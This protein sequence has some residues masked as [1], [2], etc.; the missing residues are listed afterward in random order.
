MMNNIPEKQSQE[1][2]R[3]LLIGA[4]TADQSSGT[5]AEQ[6][7]ELRLLVATLNYD[8]E[9]LT[10]PLKRIDPATF[11]GS[12]KVAEIKNLLEELKIDEIVFNDDL[13][14][15]QMRNLERALEMEI[16]DRSGIILEI[17]AS[18]A[19]T[20]EAKTQVELATLEYLLP[21][22][23]R[24]WTHLERQIGGIN[25]RGGAGE[26]QIETDKRLIKVRISRLKK[27]L[28]RIEN[29]RVVQRK[30]RRGNYN[31]SLVGYTNAGKSTLMNLFTGS[32][33]LVEDKLF[34]TLDTTV[35][36]CQLD[37]F[38]RILLSDT[39]GFIR[40]LPHHL[41]AS[42]RGTLKEIEEADLIV[43]VAD[44]SHPQ[45]L[46][47]LQTVEEVM[48]DLKVSHKPSIVVFNKID[49]MDKEIFSDAKRIYPDAVFLSALNRLKT[50]DLRR[51]VIA[52]LKKMEIQMMIQIPLS[53]VR[54]IAY[55]RDHA[56]IL[57]EKYSDEHILLEII[58]NR[59]IW[60][61][62]HRKF[63]KAAIQPVLREE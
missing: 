16:R 23:T 59:K 8:G 14:P 50:D 63:G 19:R 6:L 4:V 54:D 26:T 40:K 48:A 30:S 36:Q 2:E 1:M 55:V 34:A 57:S 44:I 62:I 21:R 7:E 46:V 10:V 12:G 33:V 17:F 47:H 22:L 28:Q 49:R 60:E 25:V 38:H 11:I 18:H 3:V 9:I 42:F 43:K 31:V 24:R 56:F 58:I 51:A 20:R 32:E 35:R 13:S 41:V 39:V 52:E 29:D 27:E 45:C 53:E 5:I 37:K 61:Q 15:T